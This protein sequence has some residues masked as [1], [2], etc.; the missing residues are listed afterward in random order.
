MDGKG[1]CLDNIFT[2]RLWRSVK[3]ENIYRMNYEN[4][5]ATRIGLEE[6]FTFYNNIRP[7]QSL[8]YKFPADVYFSR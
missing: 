8:N 2:E 5:L 7:H 1:R 4:V 6:Y 3:Q